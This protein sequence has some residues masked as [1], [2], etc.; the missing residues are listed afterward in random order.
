[1]ADNLKQLTQDVGTAINPAGAPGSILAVN[2]KSVL[3]QVIE[4]AGKYTGLPFVAK[5]QSSAGIIMPGTFVWNGNAMNQNGDFIITVSKYT[6]DMNDVGHY[7]SLLAEGTL[8][9]FKDFVGR[10]VILKYKSHAPDIDGIS[11]DIFNIFVSGVPENTNYTYQ[12][13]ESEVCMIEFF[14]K[15]QAGDAPATTLTPEQ[16]QSLINNAKPS[17]VE[18][19]ANA[20]LSSLLENKYLIVNGNVTLTI[21]TALLDTFLQCFIF[22]QTGSLTIALQVGVSA[23]GYYSLVILPNERTTITK[24]SPTTNEYIII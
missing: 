3:T 12:A 23:I 8:I 20:N 17:V 22:V 13:N 7:L 19:T 15:S 24:R 16:I 10:S 6:S 11:N 5:L 18:F 4:K 14:N 1:M 2:H 21:P 9:H